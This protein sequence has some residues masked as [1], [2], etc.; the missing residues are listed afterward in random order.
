MKIPSPAPAPSIV[1]QTPLES[2]TGQ[3]ITILKFYFVK[4]PI[5]KYIRKKDI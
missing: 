2:L 3:L 4:T 5:V 1:A